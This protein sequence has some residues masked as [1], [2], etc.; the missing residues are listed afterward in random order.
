[1]ACLTTFVQQIFSK[2]LYSEP[3]K[4]N[5]YINPADRMVRCNFYLPQDLLDCLRAKAVFRE[6]TA[7]AEIRKA[8]DAYCNPSDQRK[9][10]P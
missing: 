9:P 5:N 1:M 6:T 7:S 10:N 8:L 2:H 4:Q 3:M